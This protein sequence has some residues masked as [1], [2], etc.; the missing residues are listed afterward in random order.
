MKSKRMLTIAVLALTGLTNIADP[1]RTPA[2][3]S[4]A[5]G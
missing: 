3:L 4:T 1:K 5:A 2:A